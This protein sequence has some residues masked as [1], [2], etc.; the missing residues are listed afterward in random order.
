MDHQ[1]RLAGFAFV[2]KNM[3]FWFN[4]AI[5]NV[6]Y[7]KRFV[8]MHL[9]WRGWCCPARFLEWL[10]PVFAPTPSP[11][12]LPLAKSERISDL[13]YIHQVA[14]TW[15]TVNA[16]VAV[17][18]PHPLYKVMVCQWSLFKFILHVLLSSH[19]V[20]F[21]SA[22]FLTCGRTIN[23]HLSDEAS[24]L[25]S[26]TL[27]FFFLPVLISLHRM[28]VSVEKGK[29]RHLNSAFHLKVVGPINKASGHKGVRPVWGCVRVCVCLAG[30]RLTV[31]LAESV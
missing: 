7:Q 6:K 14:Q 10:W 9:I 3:H 31:S 23:V 25:S 20:D 4:Q 17:C 30:R 16:N 26:V 13:L 15:L 11:L 18:L 24:Q 8:Q 19:H 22:S 1:K 5:A 27:F 28:E 29:N 2:M 12:V 21:S